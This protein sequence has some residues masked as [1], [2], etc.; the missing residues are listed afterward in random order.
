MAFDPEI[1]A[2]GF[3]RIGKVNTVIPY[4]FPLFPYVPFKFQF[5]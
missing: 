5:V 1:I 2:K 4:V 3:R